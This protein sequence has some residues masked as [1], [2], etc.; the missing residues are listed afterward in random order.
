MYLGRFFLELELFLCLL[1]RLFRAWEGVFVSCMGELFCAANMFLRLDFLL[2][3][4]LLLLLL[5]VVVVG[6]VVG[7]VTVVVG[8]WLDL[9][10][11]FVVFVGVVV[12]MVTVVV[13]LLHKALQ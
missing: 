3:F 12:G 8:L 11:L 6:V 7:M 1:R 5:F 9:L 13:G 4:L 2:F 10:L